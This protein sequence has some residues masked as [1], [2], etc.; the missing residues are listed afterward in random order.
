MIY[1][2][3]NSFGLI[4]KALRKNGLNEQGKPWNRDVLGRAVHLTAD[5]LGRLERG[6]RKNIDRQTLTL[7]ADAF[8]LT[9]HERKEFYYAALGLQDKEIFN[10]EEPE[11]RLKNLVDHAEKLHLPA[12]ILDVYLDVIATNKALL[13]LY[14]IDPDL[15]EA[16][17]GKPAGYNQLSALYSSTPGLK[18]LMG[19][20]WKNASLSSILEFRRSSLR[21]RHTDYFSG[22]L[23]S[24]FKLKYFK[25][26]WHISHQY[27]DYSNS[28]Y[29][30]FTYRHC[31]FGLLDYTI[32]ET[33]INTAAGELNLILHNPN[34]PGTLS[35]FGELT[36]FGGANVLKFAPWPEKH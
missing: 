16:C 8:K 34:D 14:Q 18:K 10:Q 12:L 11:T 22:L 5:Q 1:I 30:R 23:N 27:N 7:L 20:A 2:H 29:K 28:V 13:N 33:R 24:L 31:I 25:K 17:R 35:T 21:Y 9:S 6:E 4:V 36:R 26:D 3:S 15:I 32:S 19:P